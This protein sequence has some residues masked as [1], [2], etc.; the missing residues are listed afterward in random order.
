VD[1]AINVTQLYYHNVNNKLYDIGCSIL[2]NYWGGN[3]ISVA[4]T[5][6][7]MLIIRSAPT[8]FKGNRIDDF[9]EKHPYLT[10]CTGI[11]LLI[12]TLMF[13]K[14]LSDNLPT[15]KYCKEYT[16]YQKI[17]I[18]K[19]DEFTKLKHAEKY[20]KHHQDIYIIIDSECSEKD[21]KV[22]EIIQ[23]VFKNPY[24][25]NETI[26]FTICKST[27]STQEKSPYS[28]YTTDNPQCSMSMTYFPQK[29][30]EQ[31]ETAQPDEL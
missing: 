15:T 20:M 21:D 5:L 23:P 22:T 10:K 19:P 24:V 2:T 25:I 14:F 9:S 4:P 26:K 12:P 13:S 30:L 7:S 8:L 1:D 27:T 31:S 29:E 28:P 6:T 3:L 17:N 16:D 18:T 11:L